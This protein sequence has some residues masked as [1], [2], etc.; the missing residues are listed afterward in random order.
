MQTSTD[1]LK[2]LGRRTGFTVAALRYFAQDLG[3]A[4][5]YSADRRTWFLAE[6]A[7]IVRAFNEHIVE[8]VR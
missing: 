5:D 3:L 1:N 4:V 2:A 6:P 7:V 8:A